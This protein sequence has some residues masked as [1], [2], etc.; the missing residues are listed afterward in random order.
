MNASAVNF[1]AAWPLLGDAVIAA[2]VLGFTLAW[3]GV[4]I[5][6]RRMVF[7][8][9]AVTQVAGAGV[10]LGYFLAIAFDWPLDPLAVAAFLTTAAMALLAGGSQN[11]PRDAWVGA[12]FAAA[13]AM[14]LLLESQIVV[15]AHDIHAILF[16]SAVLVGP[17]D[18]AL[19]GAICLAVMAVQIA[20]RQGFGFAGFYPTA[21][22]VQGL[23][24]MQL[25]LVLFLSFGLVVGIGSRALGAMPVFAFAVLPP[26]AA[27]ALARNFATALALAAGLGAL[28]GGGGYFLAFV[29]DQPVGA[30]QSALGCGLWLLA[31][32]VA[33]FRSA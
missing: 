33:K 14:T 5:V 3:L 17:G 20:G 1:I 11:R 29:L 31:L 27:L 12:V 26:L 24:V 15:E 16:G 25:N 22:R 6:E 30:T 28:T 21:A 4:Y 7:V 23:P 9:A 19:A 18:L 13:S 10:A 8:A 32:F 2:I